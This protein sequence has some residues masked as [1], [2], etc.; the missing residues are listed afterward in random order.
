M[1]NTFPELLNFGLLAPTIIRLILAIILLVLGYE[2]IFKKRLSFC[3]YFK[4]KEYPLAA[5]LPWKLGIAEIITG[6]FLFFGFFTQIASIVSMY[7][8]FTL[9]YI[10]N[11]DEKILPHTS[12]FYLVMIFVSATL[13]FSGAG[14]FAVDLPL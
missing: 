12:T 8:F 3:L 14:I 11:R 2:T 5:F 7:L 6:I 13:L 1:L 4:A 9:L 10:E